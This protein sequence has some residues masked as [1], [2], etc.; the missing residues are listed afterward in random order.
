MIHM[1]LL[2]LTNRNALLAIAAGH[3]QYGQRGGNSSDQNAEE[4]RSRRTAA[5]RQNPIEPGFQI[6]S[7]DCAH[8]C[9]IARQAKTARF[10]QPAQI[11]LRRSPTR[12]HSLVADT[13]AL[14]DQLTFHKPKQRMEPESRNNAVNECG[15]QIIAPTGVDQLVE[16]DGLELV[17]PFGPVFPLS[18]SRG[19]GQSEMRWPIV[20]DL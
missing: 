18:A 6:G 10:R 19:F 16:Q 13:F 7:T 1:I 17:D 14:C 20:I 2:R 4:V 9:D 3:R 11:D 8:R 12:K 15:Q 5:I